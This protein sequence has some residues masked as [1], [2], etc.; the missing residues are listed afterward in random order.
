MHRHDQAREQFVTRLL[1]VLAVITVIA[2]TVIAIQALT[3]L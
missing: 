3:A 1:T 2:L